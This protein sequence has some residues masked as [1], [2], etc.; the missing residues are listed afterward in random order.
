MMYTNEILEFKSP[1][2]TNQAEKLNKDLRSNVS[3]LSADRNCAT[4]QIENSC[5]RVDK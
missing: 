4:V 3:K 1:T 2:K 5:L